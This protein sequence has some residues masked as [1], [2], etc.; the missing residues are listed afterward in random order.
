MLPY[1]VIPLFLV[2]DLPSPPYSDIWSTE[3]TFQVHLSTTTFLYVQESKK[4]SS[5]F[6]SSGTMPSVKSMKNKYVLMIELKCRNYE[7]N[8]LF[9]YKGM[10]EQY[11]PIEG[12]NLVNIS[13]LYQNTIFQVKFSKS[14]ATGYAI[15]QSDDKIM[16]FMLNLYRFFGSQLSI[17]AKTTFHKDRTFWKLEESV[18]GSCFTHF[19]IRH[20]PN[21]KYNKHVLGENVTLSLNGY[22]FENDETILISKE[23]NM[24]RCYNSFNYMFGNS[25]WSELL[26]DNTDEELFQTFNCAKIKRKFTEKDKTF[27]HT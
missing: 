26:P 13:D 14:G 21:I 2:V 22:S 15:E 6:Y 23:R 24:Q 10:Q 12:R 3:Y 18:L 7:K 9:C 16:N 4:I 11:H 8:A 20:Q 17:G 25:Y 19:V 5:D 27:A 1:F